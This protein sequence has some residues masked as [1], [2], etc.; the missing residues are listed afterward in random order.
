MLAGKLSVVV[1]LCAIEGEERLSWGMASSPYKYNVTIMCA[2]CKYKHCM[3]HKTIPANVVFSIRHERQANSVVVG[4]PLPKLSW[5]DLGNEYR[6]LNP[7]SYY[8]LQMEMKP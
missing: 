7:K 3:L 1:A 5:D 8:L 2:Y 4:Q 6:A